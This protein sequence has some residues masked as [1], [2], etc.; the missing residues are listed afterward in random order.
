MNPIKNDNYQVFFDDSLNILNNILA[1]KKYSKIFILVDEQT[2]EHCLPVLQE[3]LPQLTE[4]DIIEVPNGEENKTIDF[5]IGIWRTLLDFEADRN[6]LL[7]NLGGGVVTD[8]GSFAAATYKRGID[9][10][11]IP[12]TLL[13]QVDA[14]VGGKTGIDM[15]NVK[16]II[17]TFSQPQAV[18]I[19]TDFLKTLPERELTSGLAEVLKHGIIAD[20]DFFDELTLLNDAKE[21]TV[22][23][24][25]KSVSIKNKVVLADPFEKNI[26]K[27]LNYGHTIGHAIESWSLVNEKN[28]LLHGE[29]IAIGMICEAY[30]AKET[31]ELSE[32]EL[33]KITNT[34]IKFFGRY[35]IRPGI[36]NALLDI[37]KQDK[38]NS[39]GKISFSLPTKIGNCSID[40]FIEESLILDSLKYYQSI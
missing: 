30:L 34:F 40:S 11:Q 9:F 21:I 25:H 24:I 3:K 13:S 22:K 39:N 26:R 5:C 28:S 2:S 37:M 33:E 38:K 36:E 23:H 29:A 12:T 7:I 8:M 16:N 20:V 10:L 4:F 17:G 35:K 27:T 32:E 31:N 15:D 1:Q 14:S 19:C 6:A 18:I